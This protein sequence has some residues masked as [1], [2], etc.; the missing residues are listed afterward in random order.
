MRNFCIPSPHCRKRRIS[1]IHCS[2]WATP[3]ILKTLSQKKPK[4]NSNWKFHWTY[5]SLIKQENKK[6]QLI[7]MQLNNNVSQMT[8]SW[9]ILGLTNV[10]GI[11]NNWF[12]YTPT[13]NVP[14]QIKSLNVTNKYDKQYHRKCN[15]GKTTDV[16][17][18]KKD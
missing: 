10:R 12:S 7:V 16:M 11:A 6:A 18:T 15:C 4:L 2:L 17:N 3:L 8:Y 13:M 9:H 5:A 14:K 1:F